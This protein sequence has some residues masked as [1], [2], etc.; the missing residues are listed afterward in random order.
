[1]ECVEVARGKA[2]CEAEVATGSIPRPKREEKDY[3]C[4]RALFWH[5][6][7]ASLVGSFLLSLENHTLPPPRR[8]AIPPPFCT[9]QVQPI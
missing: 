9:A 6:T 2:S 3:R 8:G 5:L 7:N 4:P 1:M